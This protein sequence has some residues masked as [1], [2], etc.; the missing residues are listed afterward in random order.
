MNG[1]EESVF[2]PEGVE[3]I[4]RKIGYDGFFRLYRYSLRHRLFSGGWTPVISRE[5]FERGHAV[6]VLPYDPDSDNVVLVEQFR[7]GALEA[8]GGPWLLECVAG[9]IEPGESVPEVAHREAMEEAGCE[10]MELEF[11]SRYLVSPGGTSEQITL[12]CG[13]VDASG[14]GGIHGLVEEHEDIRVTPVPFDRAMELLRE[15]RINSAAPI[16]ALQWLAM[17]RE[18]LRAKWGRPE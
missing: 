12:Y 2:A 7:I 9:M 6:A 16:I 4:E 18:Q 5:L 3:I 8:K 17:N 11:V 14:I 10:L 13:K 15:G 1:N